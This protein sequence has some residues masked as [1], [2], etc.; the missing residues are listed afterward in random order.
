MVKFICSNLCLVDS[1]DSDDSV[2]SNNSNDS[3][4]K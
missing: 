3:N 4:P 2:D 1:D